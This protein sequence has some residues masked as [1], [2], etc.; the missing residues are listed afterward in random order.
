MIILQ[1]LLNFKIEKWNNGTL[2]LTVILLFLFTLYWVWVFKTLLDFWTKWIFWLNRYWFHIF[3]DSLSWPRRLLF[4]IQFPQNSIRHSSAIKK[5]N[6]HQCCQTFCARIGFSHYRFSRYRFNH[7][8]FYYMHLIRVSWKLCLL[9][10]ETWV[11]EIWGIL[12]KF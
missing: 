12:R 2:E 4:W 8:R 3:V 10:R 11:I 5:K 1:Y 7:Y 9:E 6:C